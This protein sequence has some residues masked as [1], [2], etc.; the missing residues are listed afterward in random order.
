[1]RNKGKDHTK[2]FY[3][4][5]KICFFCWTRP[6]DYSIPARRTPLQTA[7]AFK[8]RSRFASETNFGKMPFARDHETST[9]GDGVWE[10]LSPDKAVLFCIVI[11]NCMPYIFLRVKAAGHLGQIN[12]KNTLAS[13]ARTKEDLESI[14]MQSSLNIS[15][16]RKTGRLPEM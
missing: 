3:S 5:Y 1:V 16:T 12:A 9:R 14:L 15:R 4:S 8:D 2:E 10:P 11:E 6:I 7:N 13:H